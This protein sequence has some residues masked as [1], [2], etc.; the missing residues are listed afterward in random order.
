MRINVAKEVAH[1]GK[2]GT[3]D[4]RARYAEVFGEPTRSGNRPWLVKRIAWRLQAL[5]EGGLSDRARQRAEELARDA[6][7]RLRPPAEIATGRFARATP[8]PCT[9]PFKADQ[10]VPA[11]G[12]ILTRRYKGEDLR[13][14]VLA[15]GFEYDGQVYGSLSAVAKAVTGTHCNGYH[16]FRD[17]LNG[18]GGAK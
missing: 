15:D 4:L 1:L 10:R 11:P 7:L 17:V 5:A 18:Q 9:I 13:V 3:A 6:D 2:L 8:T 16:F 12:T 14:Q